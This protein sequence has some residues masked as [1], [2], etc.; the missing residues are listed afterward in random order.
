MLS[1]THHNTVPFVLNFMFTQGGYATD[2]DLWIQP[3]MCISLV[4][5]E[6]IENTFDD[7]DAKENKFQLSF[8]WLQKSCLV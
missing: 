7:Q 2:L 4:A 6:L 1:I 3:T 5:E 8:T